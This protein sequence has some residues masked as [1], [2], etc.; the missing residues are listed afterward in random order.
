MK[1]NILTLALIFT[2]IMVFQACN[3][4]KEKSAVNESSETTETENENPTLRLAWTV[5]EDIDTPES[6]LFYADSGY[7][8][9]S[10]IAGKPTEKNMQGYISVLDVDGNILFPKWSS[11]LNAPKGMAIFEGRLYV[12]DID[13]L[14]EIDLS[15]GNKVNTYTIEGASF[16]NDVKAHSDGRIFVSDSDTGSIYVLADGKLERWIYDES[17][18]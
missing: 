1:F 4:K 18:N 3:S 7:L 14:V 6:V 2:T 17:F 15:S 16:M 13:E 8:F 12:A 10:N 9:V 5:E 11:E